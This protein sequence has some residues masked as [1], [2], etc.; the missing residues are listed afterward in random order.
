MQTDSGRVLHESIIIVLKCFSYELGQGKYVFCLHALIESLLSLKKSKL[1]QLLDNAE[2]E[3]RNIP[4]NLNESAC[5]SEVGNDTVSAFEVF[6][7]PNQSKHFVLDLSLFI[8]LFIS[9]H[10]FISITYNSLCTKNTIN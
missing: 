2:E 10:L 3:V 9:F 1:L 7:H 4:E 5:S 8:L 6:C